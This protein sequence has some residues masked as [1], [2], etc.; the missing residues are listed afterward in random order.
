MGGQNV[1]V[2]VERPEMRMVAVFDGADV[3][4]ALGQVR[5]VNSF[6]GCLQEQF[7]RLFQMTQDTVENVS[8]E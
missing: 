4:Q 5:Q 2:A 6:R 3:A 1:M 7:G 8:A